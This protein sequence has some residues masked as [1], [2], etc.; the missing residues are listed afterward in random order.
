M[1]A[2]RT[3]EEQ[4]Q[5]RAVVKLDIAMNFAVGNTPTVVAQN[6]CA[7][8]S[9]TGAGAYNIQLL[10]ADGKPMKPGYAQALIHSYQWDNGSNNHV[11]WGNYDQAN[12]I[13]PFTIHTDGVTATAAADP[14][15]AANLDLKLRLRF[16]DST[17]AKN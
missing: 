13:Q 17:A 11:R 4:S 12:G 8:V 3:H 5:T 7:S 16:K 15:D 10:G 14:V 9:R 2:R 6:S 1:S